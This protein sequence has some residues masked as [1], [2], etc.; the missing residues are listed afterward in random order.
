MYQL[1]LLATT[2]PAAFEDLELLDDRVLQVAPQ[3]TAID[4]RLKLAECPDDPIIAP[5][6]G[7]SVT[8]RCPALGWRLRVPIAMPAVAAV[9]GEMVIRKGEMVE[10]VSGGPGFAVSTMMLALDDAAAGQSVRV[11]S[12]TSSIVVTAMAKAR[13]LV[14]F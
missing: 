13:G 12:P 4:K 14:S 1:L 10:C 6:V 5:P 3:A 7:G 11:K 8:V 9:T 2:T